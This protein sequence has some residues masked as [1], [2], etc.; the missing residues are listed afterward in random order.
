MLRKKA[1]EFMTE[2]DIAY[3]LPQC[4][5]EGGPDSGWTD[6]NWRNCPDARNAVLRAL[7]KLRTEITTPQAR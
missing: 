3:Y 6:D 5:D 7:A 2:Q 1:S 4:I